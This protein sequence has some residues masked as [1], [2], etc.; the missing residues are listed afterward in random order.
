MAA[1]KAKE[2]QEAD[3]WKDGGQPTFHIHLIRNELKRVAKGLSKAEIAANKAAEQGLSYF[4]PLSSFYFP[5]SPPLLPTFHSY[6]TTQLQ[7]LVPLIQAT[8]NVKDQQY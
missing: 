7:S 2:A 3:E 1:N 5:L 8:Y 6:S 4:P